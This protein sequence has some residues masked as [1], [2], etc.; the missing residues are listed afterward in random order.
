MGKIIEIFKNRR[1]PDEKLKT[2]NVSYYYLATGMEGVAD[3]HDYG[4][5][6]ANDIDD[7]KEITKRRFNLS[8]TIGL[9]AKRVYY[10]R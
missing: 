1:N 5:V 3:T 2:F 9:E 7:A 8:S 10:V 6:S 4:N